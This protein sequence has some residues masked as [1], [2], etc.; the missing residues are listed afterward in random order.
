MNIA[1]VVVV[2]NIVVVV[3]VVGE[4][5]AAAVLPNTEKRVGSHLGAVVDSRGVAAW[6]GTAD[7]FAVWYQMKLGELDTGQLPCS[8]HR[9]DIGEEEDHGNSSLDPPVLGLSGSHRNCLE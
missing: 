2:A 9:V 3:V 8:A 5:A 1:A 4:Q 6:E 7:S